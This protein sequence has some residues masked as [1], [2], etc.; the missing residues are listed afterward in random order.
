MIPDNFKIGKAHG[1]AA[2]ELISR[3]IDFY[4]G[5]FLD[6]SKM[7]W[8]QVRDTAQSFEKHI[9]TTWPRY[10]EEI[11][12]VADGCGRDILDIVAL[13]VRT[14]IA[15]GSFTDGCTSLSW[16][17]TGGALLGQN[18]DWMPEQ[19][20]NMLILR[21]KGDGELPSIAMCTE[22]GIIGKIG[23][24]SNGVGVCLNAIRTKGCEPKKLPVHLG[25]RLALESRSA[26]EAA[27]KMEEIGMASAGHIL[28]A[29]PK[30]SIGFEF[31]TKTF[32]RLLKDDKSC[33][34]H[35]NHLLTKHPGIDEPGWLSDSPIRVDTINKLASDLVK[36]GDPT[37]EAFSKLFEDEFNYPSAI[38]R[39]F[40]DKGVSG[41]ET[42]FNIVMD[43]KN[44]TGV[45]KL[46]RPV[47]V[48]ETIKLSFD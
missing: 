45:V 37:F 20:K 10:Y 48:D 3:G 38:C 28:I 34:A 22:A 12:G 30:E 32:A 14:E 9:K 13:N 31:T 17:G 47:A 39:V 33:V 1:S 5:I 16:H 43:L 40:D 7:T 2:K 35:S 21:I 27:D 11:K 44:K 19:K 15:F 46:G 42:L 36:S 26:R 29:D 25:L 18:W 24:N 8:A 6:R 23:L 4:T 41:A